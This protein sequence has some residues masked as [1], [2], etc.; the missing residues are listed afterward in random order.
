MGQTGVVSLYFVAAQRYYALQLL[1]A[2]RVLESELRRCALP[3]NRG[4]ERWPRREQIDQNPPTAPWGASAS[5]VLRSPYV[6]E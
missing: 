4:R 2:V 1:D 6:Q 3:G 5:R